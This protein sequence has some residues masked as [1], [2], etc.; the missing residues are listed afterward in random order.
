MYL[1][2]FTQTDRHKDR[3]TETD[4]QTDRGR[5]KEGRNRDL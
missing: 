3:Q 4:K 5:Q 2:R 1:A